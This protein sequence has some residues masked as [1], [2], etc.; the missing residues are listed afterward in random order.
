MGETTLRSA[1]NN[2]PRPHVGRNECMARDSRSGN[3]QTA[4]ARIERCIPRG[5]PVR[6][7]TRTRPDGRR[8]IYSTTRNPQP[9]IRGSLPFEVDAAAHTCNNGADKGFVRVAHRRERRRADLAHTRV[10]ENTR[11]QE[12]T[13]RRAKASARNSKKREKHVSTPPRAACLDK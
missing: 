6:I 3:K 11:T 1:R 8:C 2:N 5:Q 4:G 9:E 7:R 13:R 12:Q 10:I